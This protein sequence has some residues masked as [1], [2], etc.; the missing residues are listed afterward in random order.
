MILSGLVAVVLA[1]SLTCTVKFD[2]PA[3]EG[4]PEIVPPVA[5]VSPSGSDPDVM[6]QVFP[7]APPVAFRV[8][9]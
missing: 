9:E 4:V 8:C 3:V 5:S 6:L 2:V 1:E 7:P